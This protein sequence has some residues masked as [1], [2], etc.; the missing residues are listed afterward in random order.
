MALLLFLFMVFRRAGFHIFPFSAREGTAAYRMKKVADS[1]KVE[2]EKRLR[3]KRDELRREYLEKMSNVP[4]NVLF[5]TSEDGFRTGYSEYYVKF[6]VETD[7]EYGIINPTALYKDGL[8]GE[9]IK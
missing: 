7:T 8:K 1:V 3:T 5:E 6:Y 4:Q 2:R 9:P